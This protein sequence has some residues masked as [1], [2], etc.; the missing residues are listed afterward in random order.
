LYLTQLE[1]VGLINRDP[2]GRVELLVSTPVGFGPGSKCLRA[3]QG[4]FMKSIVSQVVDGDT[5][6]QGKR[7]RFAIMKPLS[8]HQ[9]QFEQMAEELLAIVDRYSFLSESPAAQSASTAKSAEPW[10]LAIAAGSA[11][12]SKPDDVAKIRNIT[13]ASLRKNVR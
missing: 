4:E 2:R 13:R 7:K 1:K 8:L 11:S 9:K 6:T 5:T 12:E 3:E 10:K